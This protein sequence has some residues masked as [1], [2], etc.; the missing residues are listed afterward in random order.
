M[1]VFLFTQ[2]HNDSVIAIQK[3]GLLSPRIPIVPIVLLVC[4]SHLSIKYSPIFRFYYFY[5][6]NRN[7][8]VVRRTQPA[9]SDV[10]VRQHG[11]VELEDK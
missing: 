1:F 2:S 9:N 11:A 8:D 10:N 5:C 7:D 3:E 6:K 4:H